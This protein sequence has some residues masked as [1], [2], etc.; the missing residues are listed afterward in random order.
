MFFGSAF[1]AHTDPFLDA[2]ARGRASTCAR[3]R[4]ARR[5]VALPIELK[6]PTQLVHREP[7]LRERAAAG[8]RACARRGLRAPLRL[9]RAE[10]AL[11]SRSSRLLTLLVFLT[12][13]PS[14][15]ARPAAARRT[16]RCRQREGRRVRGAPRVQLS[17][18]ARGAR[19]ACGRQGVAARA[20]RGRRAL[21]C[22]ESAARA[23]SRA[24]A[25]SARCTRAAGSGRARQ[26]RDELLVPRRAPEPSAGQR[27]SRSSEARRGGAR[28]QRR[29]GRLSSAHYLWS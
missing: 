3:S 16:S 22:D 24:G 29:E 11:P 25:T 5:A 18:D 17:P 27:G 12:T 8:G 19:R 1:G 4:T 26:A 9:C 28:P 10:P 7:P 6:E 2:A 13:R 23:R 15:T 21:S 20:A 14:T